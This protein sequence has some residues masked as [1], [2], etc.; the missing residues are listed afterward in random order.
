MKSS[1][2]SLKLQNLSTS[3]ITNVSLYLGGV[4]VNGN[5]CFA[6]MSP[7]F[8]VISKYFPAFLSAFV[9]CSKPA[10]ILKRVDLPQPDEP[11]RANG[12]I[13]NREEKDSF[14]KQDIVNVNPDY[15]FLDTIETNNPSFEEIKP[16][17][18]SML[19]EITNILM[20]EEKEVKWSQG[21][22]LC[23]DNCAANKWADEGTYLRVIY[24]D[25]EELE[26]MEKAPVFIVVGGNTLSRGLT[27]EG[28]CCS[29]FTRESN[30]ADTLMQMA[31]WFGYRKGY[32]L[33]QRIWMTNSNLL[34]YKALTKIDMDMKDE[35][36]NFMDKG[37]SP[38]K[39]GPKIRNVPEI[40]K[41]RI[42]SKNKSQSAI[43]EDFDFSGDTYETTNFDDGDFLKKNFEIAKNFINKIQNTVSAEKSW[44]GNAF[45][46]NEI[47]YSIIKNDFL[48][49]YKISTNDSMFDNMPY[50]SQWMDESNKDNKFLKWNVAIVNG[51]N[52]D[53]F[54][55][56]GGILNKSIS[57]T[58]KKNTSWIDIGS[59]R[60]GPDA[61]CDVNLKKL[62]KD[63]E[64][65]FNKTIKTKKGLAA[66]RQLFNLEDTPLLLLYRIAKKGGV[67]SQRSKNTRVP[68]DAKYDII[69]ISIIVPGKNIGGNH[70]KRL[71]IKMNN[72]KEDEE[73]VE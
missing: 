49:K 33:F 8:S 7:S 55:F 51:E 52:Q 13:R 32:E 45:V 6:I 58:R 47:S 15:A 62:D 21:I 53:T 23:V 59:L 66:K 67:V 70:A 42:T 38:S 10:S 9:G 72:N 19:K 54:N 69:G 27:I 56:G 18:V 2:T 11:K 24:P 28:L 68:M 57:R 3:T 34:K 14:E 26:K 64:E 30:L 46:W 50:F 29:Y 44:N 71:T 16:E 40:A 73:D 12:T 65:E 36:Q 60:S 35:V 4:T 37:L 39:F 20:N 22:N 1:S 43:F 25:D 17:I 31:R 63:Q 48:G 41:F 5:I 61:L